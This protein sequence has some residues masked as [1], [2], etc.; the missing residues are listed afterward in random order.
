M[1]AP[2]PQPGRNGQSLT[3]PRNNKDG[4]SK[5]QPTGRT[6]ITT[7]LPLRQPALRT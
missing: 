1:P 3:D 4:S 6:T 7:I 5:P 2:T